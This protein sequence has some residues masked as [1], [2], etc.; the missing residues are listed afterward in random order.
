MA[1]PTE[2]GYTGIHVHF[3][4]QPSSKLPLLLAAFQYKFAR[5]AEVMAR[6]LVDDVVIGWDELGTDLLDNAPPEITEALTGGQQ[7]PSRTMDH[8]ITTDGS[9]PVRM[10]VTEHSAADQDIQ[11]GY[12]LRPHGIE[13]LPVPHTGAGPVVGWDTDPR[14]VFSDDPG[15]WTSPASAP[16]VVPLRAARPPRTAPATTAEKPRPSARR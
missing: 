4:G 2:T 6:H 7:W 12:I 14:T 13:V 3:D 16:V 1:R 9:P 10:T 11:W 15:H 8:L 5:D